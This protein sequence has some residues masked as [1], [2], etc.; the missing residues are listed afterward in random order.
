MHYDRYRLGP[1]GWMLTLLVWALVS[2]VF[3]YFFFR[4]Y[5]CFFMIFLLFPL[6]A[7]KVRK[8]CISRRKWNLKTQFADALLG[9]STALSSGNSMENAFR[10]AY[11]EMCTMH[12]TQSDIARELYTIVKGMDNN[13]TVESQLSEFASR[14]N[15]EEIEDFADIFSV[16]KR[17]G[18]NMKEIMRVCCNTIS[19]SVELQREFRVML[20]SRQFEMQ[21][22]S[23]VPFGIILYIGSASSGYFDSLY[24]S[25]QGVLI[26]SGCLLMYVIAYLWGMKVIEKTENF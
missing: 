14:S 6:F 12:G 20:S 25:F 24:H 18:G 16:G 3:A 22:M 19:E 23:V 15:I 9:I 13:L 17:S 26:M 11:M 10:K 2:A 4:S 5:L 7:S 8:K 1:K 21:I